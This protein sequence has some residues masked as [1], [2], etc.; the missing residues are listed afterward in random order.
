MKSDG[1]KLLDEQVKKD[2]EKDGYEY[3]GVL[4]AEFQ[5]ES[6]EGYIFKR[7][8]EGTGTGTEIKATWQ[9]IRLWQ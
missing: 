6:S 3:L 1:T 2:I 5:G 7:V 4:E 9:K 8:Q